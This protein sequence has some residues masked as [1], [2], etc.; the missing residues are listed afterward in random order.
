MELKVIGTGSSGNAYLLRQG[1]DSI[2]L[3]AGLK[4]KEILA[5]VPGSISQIKACLVTHEHQDHCKSV[6]DVVNHGIPTVMS[7]GTYEYIAGKNTSIRLLNKLIPLATEEAR[8][9][10]PFTIMPVKTLH[11]ASDPVGYIIRHEPTKETMLYAT[12]TYD[13][14]NRY[15]N[16]NHWLIECN[17][18]IPKARELLDSPEKAPLFE[19]LIRSHLS[20]ERLCKRLEMN[21]LSKTRTIVLIH[22]SDERGDSELMQKTVQDQT[23]IRTIAACNGMT[24]KLG[25]CPF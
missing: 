16:I 5:A 18:T 1:G 20:L 14:P 21:D 2:L 15:P 11:D 25:N 7:Y 4:W 8:Q 23:G 24:I 19:R 3:D 22:I 9:F 17:Y 12:D 6:V 10:L 13:L